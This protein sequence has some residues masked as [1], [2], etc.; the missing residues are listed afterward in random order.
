MVLLVASSAVLGVFF[1]I[2]TLQKL[3]QFGVLKAIG[4]SMKQITMIQLSQISIL[5][6]I[7]VS[8]GLGCALGLVFVLPS[9]MP[10]L[11]DITRKCNNC[12]KLYYDFYIMWN[13]I[14]L[15]N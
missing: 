4:M 8:I 14:Y 5:S 9:S 2:L 7:G 12:I 1:Y 11:Y 10:F 3:Q 13:I 6:I 15:K